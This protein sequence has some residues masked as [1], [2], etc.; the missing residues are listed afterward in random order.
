VY[1]EKA[2]GLRPVSLR[3]RERFVDQFALPRFE[4][5]SEIEIA[6]DWLVI[7]ISF[8]ALPLRGVI[9][10]HLVTNLGV[11]PVQLLDG[12]GAGLQSVAVPGLVAR[13]LEG[14][15]RVNVGQGA[16]MTV[17]GLGASLSP[18]IGGWI[19]EKA[20]YPTAF[21]VLGSFAILSLV[22]WTVFHDDLR[23]ACRARAPVAP[24]GVATSAA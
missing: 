19:A 8:L 5:S 12:V 24:G 11:I 13:I 9:A 23:T 21:T 10:A 1:S 18:G 7:L 22:L 3:A 4:V 14:T 20:G 15:G 16:V 17:Q 6:R 2:R